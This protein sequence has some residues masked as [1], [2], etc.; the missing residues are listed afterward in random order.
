MGV[1]AGDLIRKP[2]DLGQMATLNQVLDVDTASLL[3]SEFGYTVE[4]VAFDA[5]QA[6]EEAP[7]EEKPPAKWSRGHP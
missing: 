1:K 7:D 4:N 5:E 6:I 2:M 3:A